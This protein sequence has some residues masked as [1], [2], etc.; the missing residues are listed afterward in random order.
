MAG[1]PRD[2]D[3]PD[4]APA[5]LTSTSPIP[6]LPSS[7]PAFRV[8]SIELAD[9]P[10]RRASVRPAIALTRADEDLARID[11][12]S[13]DLAGAD[14][15]G[16]EL[17]EPAPRRAASPRSYA[18]IAPLNVGTGAG[19]V[20]QAPVRFESTFQY[21]T[22]LVN[23]AALPT[24][25]GFALLVHLM[26]LGTTVFMTVGMW[27][28]ELGHAV[29]AWFAGILAIPLPF[30]TIWP[31]DE[32]S[33]LVILVVAAFWIGLSAYGIRQRN[34]AL[35]LGAGSLA[36]LQIWMTLVI[37]PGR[38]FQWVI[39]AGM[40]GELIL[41]TAMMLAFYQRFPWRWDFWRYLVLVT[42]SI[43]YVHALLRWIGVSLGVMQMPRGSA[44]GD[45]AEGDVEKLLRTHE[46]TLGTLARTYLLLALACGALLVFAYLYYLARA[47]RGARQM[48]ESTR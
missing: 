31:S 18:P 41:S 3:V 4:L 36:M 16:L 6:D 10:P 20:R 39:F 29:A 7:E 23:A 30:V 32:R 27:T 2:F 46:F 48:T 22:P 21:D 44:N 40:G 26:G 42:C 35:I 24:A 5:P 25:V 33:V 9:V 34:R 45:N 1:E 28:H 14:T 38:A 11:G 19:D 12:P 47:R 13:I 37:S 43:S 15:R 8:D 17:S